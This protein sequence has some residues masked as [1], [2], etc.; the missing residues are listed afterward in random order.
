MEREGKEEKGAKVARP[1]RQ[2]EPHN[3]DHQELGFSSLWVVFIDFSKQEFIPSNVSV[4][5]LQFI[6]LLSWN[7]LQLRFSSSRETH[8]KI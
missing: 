6:H 2:S 4:L 5:L 3:H 1:L 7:T 8:A